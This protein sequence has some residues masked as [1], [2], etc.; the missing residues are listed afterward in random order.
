MKK[1]A[2][3]TCILC[4]M[5]SLCM[6]PALAHEVSDHD[7]DA[8]MRYEPCIFCGQG[9]LLHPAYLQQAHGVWHG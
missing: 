2:V 5:V 4:M 6:L 3:C 7:A 1:R 8:S 9:Q